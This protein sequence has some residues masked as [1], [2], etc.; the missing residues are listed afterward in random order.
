MCYNQDYSQIVS[1]N[2]CDFVHRYISLLRL[3]RLGRAYRLFGWV[4]FLTYNQTVSLLMVTLVRNFMV[5]VRLLF[6]LNASQQFW[7]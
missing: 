3:L 1:H 5:G 7:K 6:I 4:T 2:Q